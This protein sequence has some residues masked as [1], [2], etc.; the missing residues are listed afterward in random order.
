MTDLL[1]AGLGLTPGSELLPWVAW[2]VA[3]TC[4]IGTAGAIVA[5]ARA[6]PHSSARRTDRFLML[7]V[8]VSGILFSYLALPH[9]E[10]RY[11]GEDVS[12]AEAVTRGPAEPGDAS[13]PPS[14][15]PAIWKMGRLHFAVTLGW[16]RIASSISVGLGWNPSE[17]EVTETDHSY[18]PTS[19]VPEGPDPAYGWRAVGLATWTLA[20]WFLYGLARR[21]GVKPMAAAGGVVLALSSPALLFH[22]NI[23]SDHLASAVIIVIGIHLQ[24]RRLAD[25]EI[26]TRAALLEG[27]VVL[28]A[29]FH[30]H[31][32][33]LFLLAPL[34]MMRLVAPSATM[35]LRGLHIAGLTTG[36]IASIAPE[37]PRMVEASKSD[38]IDMFVNYPD[39]TGL[40]LFSQRHLLANLNL[41]S[42]DSFLAPAG[43]PALIGLIVLG[44]F[45]L[46]RT[47]PPGGRKVLG[48]IT[49]TILGVVVICF[50]HIHPGSRWLLP[51]SLWLTLPLARG[52]QLLLEAEGRWK[53]PGRLAMALLVV[54]GS[55]AAFGGIKDLKDGWFATKPVGFEQLRNE[56]PQVSLS[57]LPTE[58]FG[59]SPNH[60][61]NIIAN[62]GGEWSGTPRRAMPEDSIAFYNPPVVTWSEAFSHR[63]TLYLTDGSDFGWSGSFRRDYLTQLRANFGLR[64][65]F[66]S[67]SFMALALTSEASPPHPAVDKKGQ[68][69][70]LRSGH[71]SRTFDQAN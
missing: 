17:V 34:A 36:A 5:W 12:F 55:H 50:S 20:V 52:I 9:S 28:G 13:S 31:W 58:F 46:W 16:Q 24:L 30:T 39:K 15:T 47:P 49:V 22:A 26:L 40:A 25:K 59:D 51:V 10:Y 48:I 64:P 19:Y 61:I 53:V 1:G 33:S 4:G 69:P 2:F 27:V 7:I 60:P 71:L 63:P 11:E 67:G 37:F 70:L 56:L 44:A 6:R 54:G 8:V 43:A 45:A 66:A 32:T 21:W 42:M 14:E 41:R 38:V 23:L 18:G 57:E 65:V 35:K 68:Q 62:P 29:A 3:L